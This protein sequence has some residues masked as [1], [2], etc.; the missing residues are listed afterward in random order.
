MGKCLPIWLCVVAE[1]LDDDEKHL[2]R[3]VVNLFEK[4][5]NCEIGTLE[6]EDRKAE[7]GNLMFPLEIDGDLILDSIANALMGDIIHRF[8]KIFL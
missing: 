1:C 6:G 7:F 4:T 5:F 2:A 8:I 3:R